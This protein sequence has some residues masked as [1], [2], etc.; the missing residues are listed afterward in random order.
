[1]FLPLN[2]WPESDS[3]WQTQWI[4]PI[5]QSVHSHLVSWLPAES[6][7]YQSAS[8]DEETLVGAARELGWV[9]L[10]RTRDSMNVSELGV[11]RQY[12]LLALL[13]FTSKRRRMSVLGESCP[14][15]TDQQHILN[16]PMFCFLLA[17]FS[18]LSLSFWIN[19]SVLVLCCFPVREPEGGLKLYCKGADI[20]ILERLQKDSPYQ[21]WTERALE[22]NWSCF[23]TSSVGCTVHLLSLTVYV[24]Q[25]QGIFGPHLSVKQFNI[26]VLVKLKSCWWMCTALWPGQDI[27]LHTARFYTL[28]L[29]V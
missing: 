5:R 14:L 9:F 17:L 4:S 11:T 10:S 25:C 28:S 16:L 20:V 6:P 21:D 2:H 18:T 27:A 3:Y 7:V 23:W 19:Q 15:N 8:P 24:A 1:M 29:R 13:D 22:V 26:T 12:Q